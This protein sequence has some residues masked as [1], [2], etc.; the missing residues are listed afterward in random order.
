MEII[1]K[2]TTEIEKE[3][4]LNKATEFMKMAPPVEFK[5][6]MV[7]TVGLIGQLQLAFRHP[8]NLGATREMLE[9]FVLEL[10]QRIDPSGG[11]VYQMLM[12]GFDQQFDEPFAGICSVCGCTDT[13]GCPEGCYWV[14]EN[15]CS[16]CAMREN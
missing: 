6:D 5:L 15:L 11:A 7:L 3:R 4:I 9:K 10:I 14:T 16:Q 13:Y 2:N 12:M 1:N 8:G